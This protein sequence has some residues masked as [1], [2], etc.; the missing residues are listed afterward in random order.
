MQIK[1]PAYWMETADDCHEFYSLLERYKSLGIKANSQEL[2]WKGKYHA[3]FWIGPKPCH[4][5]DE[6][7]IDFDP[8]RV[9][10][11]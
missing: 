1:L 8:P 9:D 5:L 11:Y 3:L 4:I 10:E 2:G 7:M 6:L